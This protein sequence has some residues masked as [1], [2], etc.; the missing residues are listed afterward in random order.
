MSSKKLIPEHLDPE[1]QA[2]IE[3]EVM[4]KIG[5]QPVSNSREVAG[6]GIGRYFKATEWEEKRGTIVENFLL[7]R[8]RVPRPT[9]RPFD[10]RPFES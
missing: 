7:E 9:R 6:S 2:A 10:R 5:R 1:V 8:Q 3:R 4:R